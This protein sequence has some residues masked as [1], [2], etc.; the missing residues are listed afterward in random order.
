M[1]Q[2]QVGTPRWS[3]VDTEIKDPL[4]PTLVGAQG[5]QRFPLAKAVDIVGQEIALHA[6]HADRASNYT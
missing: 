2:T 4:P 1:Q 5:F 6:V 3:T